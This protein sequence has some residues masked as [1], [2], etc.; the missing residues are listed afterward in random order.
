MYILVEQGENNDI[1]R[2]E[3]TRE[4]KLNNSKLT[5]V[6]DVVLMRNYS[7]LIRERIFASFQPRIRCEWAREKSCQLGHPKDRLQNVL[8]M[9]QVEF[10]SSAIQV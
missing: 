6:G 3:S 8:T 1:I 5:A 9:E 2:G 4:K 10:N 7:N